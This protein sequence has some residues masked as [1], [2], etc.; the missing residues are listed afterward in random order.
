MTQ[1]SSA[2][3]GALRPIASRA[4]RKQPTMPSAG[5]VRVPSKSMR[6][7]LPRLVPVIAT[8]PLRDAHAPDAAA[9]AIRSVFNAIEEG[10]RPRP[11]PKP[12]RLAA[13]RLVRDRRAQE[14]EEP[15]QRAQNEQ[16]FQHAGDRQAKLEQA[17]DRPA[18]RGP[19]AHQLRAHE[20]GDADE[21]H[22]IGPVDRRGLSQGALSFNAHGGER[23][24]IYQAAPRR[25]R[26]GLA[27]VSAPF[28]PAS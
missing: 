25:K 12:G 3:G 6:S 16:A 27:A 17:A 2:A 5:S 1:V 14:I 7:A 15:G 23:S 20:N 19:G 4:R 22:R 9:R 24:R 10:E 13:D 21:R 26:Y 8:P 28:R 11:R 18:R